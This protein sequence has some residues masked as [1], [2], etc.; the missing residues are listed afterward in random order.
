M[1]KILLLVMTVLLCAGSWMGVYPSSV[2]AAPYTFTGGGTL[3]DPFVVMTAEDLDHV[4]EYPAAY[5]IQGADIDLSGYRAGSDWVP[6]GTD[7]EKFTGTFNGNAFTISGLVIHSSSDH[8]GLFGFAQGAK[9]DNIRLVDVDVTGRDFVGG[10]VGSARSTAITGSSVVSVLGKVNGVSSVGGLVGQLE[11]TGAVIRDSY[12]A[13]DVSGSMRIAG[14]VGIDV[15]NTDGIERSYASGNVSGYSYVGGLVGTSYGSIQNSYVT[16]SVY[17]VVGTAAGLVSEL[18]ANLHNS[19]Y[20]GAV[21]RGDSATVSAA[22]LVWDLSSVGSLADS[23][24]NATLN[25]GPIAVKT[26][27]SGTVVN[28]LALSDSDMKTSTAYGTGLDFTSTWGINEGNS[29]PYLRGFSPIVRIDAMTQSKYRHSSVLN[30]KGYMSDGSRGE[31]VSV[32]YE[33]VDGDNDI[34][35][36]GS[37]NVTATGKKDDYTFPVTINAASYPEGTYT[38]TVKAV[39]HAGHVSQ[40]RS[41]SFIVDATPPVISLTGANPMQISAGSVFTDPGATALDA[42]DGNVTTAITVTGTVNANAVGSYTLTYRVEDAAGNAASVTRTVNVVDTTPPVISLTGANPM[43]V[44]AGSVFTDPG[45]TALDAV[46]GD[47]TSAITVTGAVDAHTVGSYT[48]TYRVEDA[49]GNAASETRTVNVVDTTPPV[50]SLTGANPMQVSAGGVFTDPGATA[51][52]AV[53]G[54]VTSAITV[55]G[56][57]DANTVGSYTLTYQV[58]DGAGNTASETRT[59]NVVDTTPP[60]ISLTGANPMQISEGSVFTDPG[61]TALDAVDGNLTSA[62]TV[63]GT[64]YSNLTGA[65]TITY[66]VEDAAGNTASRTRTVQVEPSS[67]GSPAPVAAKSSN[68]NLAQFALISGGTTLKLSPAF[69]PGI[70]EYTVETLGERVEVQW[71]ASD[72]GAVVKLLNQS[73]GEANSVALVAGAQNIELTVQAENGTVKRYTITVTKRSVAEGPAQE[74]GCP[75]MDI[76]GHWAEADICAAAKLGIV[77]GVDMNRF[78]PDIAVTRTEFAVM[79]VRTL[80]VPIREQ[81]ASKAFS[82]QTSIPQWARSAIYT[83]LAEGM[84]DGYPDGTFRPEQTIIRIELAAMLSKAM[85]WEI[86]EDKEVSFADQASIPDWAQSY[87]ASAYEEGLMQGRSGDLFVPLGVTTRAE[88]AVVLLRLWNILHD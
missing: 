53:Y 85:K 33:I 8:V 31:K 11:D 16:G 36:N 26:I 83:G 87:V 88:A 81:A 75:F 14:L 86:S 70:T 5:Y 17:A 54:D 32:D 79:L 22:G 66:Q 25:P 41:I 42:V 84:F 2:Q 30:I 60:V 51:L 9:L 44:S 52:D 82:D 58:V 62:I 78:A 7:S 45:A 46:Y 38:A 35:D 37:R 59:V 55:T 76:R 34:I 50:I 63:T 19:F 27:G 72:T 48:L 23:F 71:T 40:A 1:R 57:V 10:L 3:T 39:D 68:A 56:A 77:E 6:I 13:V 15:N 28:S 80:Q 74:A 12:A 43:Q 73:A 4:R 21:T 20:T 18:R 69:A 65:Y 64:V 24:Y 29:Y 47:V 49:A 61:A 67:S